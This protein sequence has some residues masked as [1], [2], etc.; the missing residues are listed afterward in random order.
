MGKRRFSPE[1][2][3]VGAGEI[4]E[5][6]QTYAREWAQRRPED[7]TGELDRLRARVEEQGHFRS[8]WL[9]NERWRIE[10]LQKALASSRSARR[11]E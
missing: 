10:A 4:R 7:I 8:D 6:K 2:E 11:S 5:I 3:V 1:A 9:G